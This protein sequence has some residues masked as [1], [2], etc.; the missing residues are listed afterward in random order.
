MSAVPNIVTMTS[1]YEH[2][3]L[4]NLQ[5]DF[6]NIL[7]LLKGQTSR[8][9]IIMLMDAMEERNFLLSLKHK[10]ELTDAK[11]K[12]PIH[13]SKIAQELDEAMKERDALLKLK[14]Q[15]D[16][17]DAAHAKARAARENS[18]SKAR[19]LAEAKKELERLRELKRLRDLKLQKALDDAA[20]ESDYSSEE[21]DNDDND[22]DYSSE[23]EDSSE[24]DDEEPLPYGIEERQRAPGSPIYYFHPETHVTSYNLKYVISMVE[25]TNRLYSIARRHGILRS[26]ERVN[27]KE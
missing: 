7:G 23:E 20:Q 19:E 1:S 4:T 8:E 5:K 26:V 18:Q 3:R 14:R 9:G 27:Y 2:K 11:A 25:K 21:E 22:S 6:S 17:A 15:K 10:K 16:L 13:K 12:T 24:E